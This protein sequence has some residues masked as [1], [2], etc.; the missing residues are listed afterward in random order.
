[1]VKINRFF[2]SKIVL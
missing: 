1:V 2:P